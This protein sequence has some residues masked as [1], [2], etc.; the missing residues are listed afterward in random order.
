M[1]P[2]E[3]FA[4][5]AGRRGSVLLES[6]LPLRYGMGQW[7][8]LAWAPTL[9]FSAK[10]R[11]LTWEAGGEVRCGEGNPWEEIRR[12]Q[13][14]PAGWRPGG[15]GPFA[16][17]LIGYFGY[18]L[19]RH[20]ERLPASTEDDLG[21]PDCVLGVYPGAL[22]YHHGSGRWQK[23]GQVDLS[24]LEAGA[25]RASEWRCQGMESDLG[26]EEFEQRVRRIQE[27]IA[28]GDVYQVNLTRRLA[29]SV[30]GADPWQ[31]YRRLRLSNPAPYAAFMQWGDHQ[32]ASSSPERFLRLRGRR[33]E[34]RPMK[35]T[36]P[37]GRTATED[38]RLS[39]ELAASEK[40]RAELAMIVDLER[41]DLGRVCEYGS[42]RTR[43]LWALERYARVHQMVGRVQGRLAA[44]AGPVELLAACFPGGSITGAPKI[45]AMQIIDELE[46]HVRGVYTGAIGYLDWRGNAD[47]SVAI[48]TAVVTGEQVYV[49]VGGGMV[50][51]SDPAAEWEET[52]HKARALLEA[53]GTYERAGDRPLPLAGRG[54]V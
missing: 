41:N 44:G 48:R 15:R 1:S 22:C 14:A 33:V 26:R 23:L 42:V 8:I 24:C 32:V 13:R 36:R 27:Y 19:G 51:D 2:S 3:L 50:A 30:P 16:G 9:I 43:S 47:L 39:R 20:L 11:R 37:R 10:G 29:V 5:L 35:G 6:S 7:S 52:C 28:Q 45:R 31:L 46:R 12:L 18:E 53:L 40:D 34:T 38:R 4:P 49:G 54:A 17:G 25:P 21:L